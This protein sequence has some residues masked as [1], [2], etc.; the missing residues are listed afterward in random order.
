MMNCIIIDDEPLALTQLTGYVKRIPFLNL[1]KS[2]H[3]AYEAMKVM[4]QEKVDLL[5]ID[6]N[7]PD[8]IGVDFVRSLATKPLV[9]LI[10]GRRLQ[11]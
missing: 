7:M 2:C 11:T 8:L 1:I 10:C 3:D 9:I 6:I 4:A 5:F